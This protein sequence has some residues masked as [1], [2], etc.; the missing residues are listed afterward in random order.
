[1]DL[2][3]VGFYFLKISLCNLLP[4]LTLIGQNILTLINQ[5][6]V[7]VFLESSLIS[8]KCK[9]NKIAPRSSLQELNIAPC[10]LHALK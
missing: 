7:G 5:E 3:D 2:Q 4:M 6:W 10:L 8:W 9:K 1:M